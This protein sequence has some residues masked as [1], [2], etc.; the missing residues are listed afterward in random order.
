MVRSTLSGRGI[1]E[2]SVLSLLDSKSAIVCVASGVR[3]TLPKNVHA[4]S[5]QPRPEGA[6]AIHGILPV[7]AGATAN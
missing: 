4:I 6:M 2:L 5:L 3:R 7:A 1:G